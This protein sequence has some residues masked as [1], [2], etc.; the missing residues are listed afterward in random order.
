MIAELPSWFTVSAIAVLGLIFGSFYN[1]VI[2]RLPEDLSLLGRSV[3]FTCKKQVP[4]HCN[5]PIL[6]YFLLRG[7]CLHC[8]HKF[9]IQYPL[10]E[11]A[12]AAIF[13]VVYM[14][15]GLSLQGFFWVV[16]CSYLLIISIIDLHHMIIPDEL[17]LSGI[18]IGFL[19]NLSVGP[20]VWWESLL[21]IFIGGGIF[22]SVAWLY[23]KI[24]K[25]EGLGGGD[26]K[27]LAMLGA[28][29]G[30]F[31]ILPI[32]LIS[33]SLGSLIGI[34]LM[35]GTRRNLKASIPFGPFLAFA[36]IVYL[37]FEAPLLQLLFAQHY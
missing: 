18:V 22:L 25:K 15:A 32:I 34:A 21:G 16:F 6:S 37:F 35:I 4:W 5:I 8:K 2:V 3:C 13:V 31:S 19:Y 12:T 17:S 10:V 24:S 28:W 9:S 1:V 23:E 36:G 33:T 30:A 27:L 29:F 7:R 14:Q 26:I 11:L 20:L